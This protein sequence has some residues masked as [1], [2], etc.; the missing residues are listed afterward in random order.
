MKKY[1]L[2][3]SPNY[4]SSWGLWEAI[5]EILQNAYDQKDREPD[6]KVEIDY[7]EEMLTI[8]TSTGHLELNSLLLGQTD[9]KD[10]GLRGQF[11]EGYKLALLVLVRLGYNVDILNGDQ[12]WTPLF[13]FNPDFQCDV[14]TIQVEDHDA[15]S[16][17]TFR[18]SGIAKEDWTKIK[19]NQCPIQNIDYVL[20]DE[21]GR[22]YVGGLYVTTIEGM[23]CGYAFSPRTVKLDR[24]RGMLSS[25][26]VQY[27]TSA[28]WT[29]DQR[30]RLYEL[31]NEDAPDVKYAEYHPTTRSTDAVYHRY[32][33]EYSADTVPVSTQREVEAVA[34]AGMKWRLVP[35]G[36]KKILQSVATWFIGER[37]SPADK[38]KAFRSKYS[39]FLN[40][41]AILDLT[42]IIEELENANNTSIPF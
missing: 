36:L 19:S 7:V 34:K 42:G 8:T 29:R 14:L 30:G 32:V 2:S 41:D 4:V 35:E 40:S 21:H 39:H 1:P 20:E 18:I 33:T 9:K 38:L 15:P 28:I 10:S 27:A 11:G 13:E 6:C 25:F 5:R 26:D 24:D 16:G 23:K 22:I 3:I 37:Q 31:L 12:I 17:V